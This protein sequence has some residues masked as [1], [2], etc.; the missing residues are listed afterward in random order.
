MIQTNT[1]SLCETIDD[2]WDD[3][4]DIRNLIHTTPLVFDADGMP[5]GYDATQLFGLEAATLGG[6]A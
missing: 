5:I 4:D 1:L 3:G 6:R 2:G